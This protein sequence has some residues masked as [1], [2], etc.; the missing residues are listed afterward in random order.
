MIDSGRWNDNVSWELHEA[1]EVPPLEL[2]TAVFCIAIAEVD[3]IV[4]TKVA[5]GWSLLGGHIE[6]NET[7]LDALVRESQEEGG[8][9]PH[10]PQLFAYKKLT[11]RVPVVHQDPTK[12]YPFPTSY[13]LYYWA[14]TKHPL[15]DPHGTEVLEHGVFT[16][17]DATRLNDSGRMIVDLGYTLFLNEQSRH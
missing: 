17:Q 2:C 15:V 8:F 6:D 1:T 10:N 3:K 4:L 16:V 7:A 13:M 5:R 12:M 11:S 14:T 9:T